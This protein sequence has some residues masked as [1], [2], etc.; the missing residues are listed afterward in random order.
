[1]A[2]EREREEKVREGEAQN[3]PHAQ[4][5][6]EKGRNDFYVVFGPLISVSIE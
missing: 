5:L 4:K 2:R 3:L 6:F 1:M